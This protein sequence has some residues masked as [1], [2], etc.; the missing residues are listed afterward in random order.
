VSRS[1]GNSVNIV[2][3][4]GLD[5]WAIEVR[6]LAEAKDF[7][8]ILCVQTGSG[9]HSASCAMGTEGIFPGGK[10]RPGRDADHSPHLVPTWWMSR[11]YTSFP[12][13]LP[14]VC[15]GTVLPKFREHSEDH[16]CWIENGSCRFS[17]TEEACQWKYVNSMKLKVAYLLTIFPVFYGTKNHYRVKNPPLALIPRKVDSTITGF[18]HLKQS[19]IPLYKPEF[20]FS[21]CTFCAQFCMRK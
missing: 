6:S 18:N 15:C 7:S 10:V 17:K 16:C 9:V 19:S 20:L 12:P 4:Y 3:G 21:N 5:N 2:S 11:S 8:S 13:A 1:R 14:H